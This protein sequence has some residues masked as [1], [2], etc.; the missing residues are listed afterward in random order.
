MIQ[1]SNVAVCMDQ[2]SHT[3]LHKYIERHR[4]DLTFF[5]LSTLVWA[6]SS[7]PQLKKENIIAY[8]LILKISKVF[9]LKVQHKPPLTP[10]LSDSLK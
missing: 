10:T 2:R 1:R 5:R 6:R 9:T 3:G 7:S 8:Q 4:A